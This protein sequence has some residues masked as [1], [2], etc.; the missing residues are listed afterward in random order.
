MPHIKTPGTLA[1]DVADRL[2]K[3]LGMLGSEHPGERATAALKADELL[4]REGLRWCDVLQPREPVAVEP[5]D[6]SEPECSD[7]RSMARTCVARAWALSDKEAAFV[8]QMTRW[9]GEPSD[10]QIDWLESIYDRIGGDQ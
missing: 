10:R 3:L 9:R 1:P 2:C 6:D 5:D 7:W 4:K 8:R